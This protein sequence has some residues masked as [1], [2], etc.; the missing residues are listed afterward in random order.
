M[1]MDR[2]NV[3]PAASVTP[4]SHAADA[5]TALLENRRAFVAYVER[6]VGDRAVAE[7]IV[8]DAFVRSLN[9]GEELRDTGLG[10]FYRVL[11]NAAVD[12]LRRRAIVNRH[13]EQFAAELATAD[14][15]GDAPGVVC[16]C[17]TNLTGALKPEY[18][19][20]LRAI[21]IEATPVKDYAAA[22]GIS[23]SNAGVRIFRARQA[24]RR[25]IARVCGTCATQGC[26]D[27]SCGAPAPR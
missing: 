23:A 22:R 19:D 4:P 10:W 25:Q 26:L 7:E 20:A 24:L 1:N 13:L 21:E 9:R 17:V 3:M 12:H 15:A 27:C 11:H 5:L 14:P 6:R 2:T 8:Q 16:G 18:A